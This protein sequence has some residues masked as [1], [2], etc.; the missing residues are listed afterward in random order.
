MSKGV[1]GPRDY[2]GADEL[3]RASDAELEAIR[4]PETRQYLR[5]IGLPIGS[6]SQ[7]LHL[8]F[9][10]PVPWLQSL[11]P[12][13]ACLGRSGGTP[14]GLRDDGGIV[15]AGAHVQTFVNTSVVALG[16]FLVL[17][18]RFVEQAEATERVVERAD[19][20]DLVDDDEAGLR[21]ARNELRREMRKID[22]AALES[23]ELFWPTILA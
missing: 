21:K 18:A 19:G 6:R 2:W 23:R 5:T 4:P 10:T 20:F 11:A 15:L 12:G 1:E 22:P 16:S 17:Y 9:S 7:A 8:D 13:L 3:R 14:L